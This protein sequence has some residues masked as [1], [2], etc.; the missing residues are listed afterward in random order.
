MYAGTVPYIAIRYKRNRIARVSH[1]LYSSHFTMLRATV[2]IC[3]VT[4]AVLTQS[5]ASTYTAKGTDSIN[6]DTI[7]NNPIDDTIVDYP[8]DDTI[9]DGSIND[10]WS[11]VPKCAADYPRMSIANRKCSRMLVLGRTLFVSMLTDTL[12]LL[13]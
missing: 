12:W 2:L 3:L 10:T 8:I 6:D 9:D 7:L 1:N 13:C 5:L 11:A 4:S